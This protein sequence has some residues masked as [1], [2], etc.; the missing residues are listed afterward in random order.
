MEDINDNAP[1]FRPFRTAVTVREDA[2]PGTLI[3]TVEAFDS[4]EGRF[5]QVFYQ[6]EEET[7]MPNAVSGSVFSIQTNDGECNYLITAMVAINLEHAP[8]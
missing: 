3:E 8:L 2:K 7:Q 5:G 4:D 1:I 6:L